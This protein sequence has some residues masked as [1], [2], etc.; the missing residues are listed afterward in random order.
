MLTQ[1]LGGRNGFLANSDQISEG[2]TE[3]PT[4]PPGN[5]L[6]AGAPTRHLLPEPFDFRPGRELPCMLHAL[7][8]GFGGPA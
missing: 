6:T 3:E 5:S 7:K 8:P 2:N 4:M 1:P